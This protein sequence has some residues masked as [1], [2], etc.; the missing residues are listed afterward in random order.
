MWLICISDYYVGCGFSVLK[1]AGHT[2]EMAG[3]RTGH[4]GPQATNQRVTVRAGC[5]F[6]L[7]DT[8]LR[9]RSFDLPCW[10]C[11][12]HSCWEGTKTRSRLLE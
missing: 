5:P 12:G 1:V 8:V 4:Q 7:L 10:G 3:C 9:A 11:E 2:S 6:R